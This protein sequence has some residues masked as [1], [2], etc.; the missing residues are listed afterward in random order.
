MA[1]NPRRF[2]FVGAAILLSIGFA[3]AIGVLGRLSRASFFHPPKWIYWAHVGFGSALLGVAIR[4]NHRWQA[5][6]TL[7]GTLAGMTLGSLGLL[8]GPAAAKRFNVPEL[9]DRSDHVAHLAVGLCGL[10]GWS[11]RRSRRTS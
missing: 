11:G 8:L 7:A 3:G 5:G 2:L 1:M 9:A 4:G 6:F 10:W